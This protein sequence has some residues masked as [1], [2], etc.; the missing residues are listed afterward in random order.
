MDFKSGKPKPAWAKDSTLFKGGLD[1]NELLSS[2][3]RSVPLSR[4]KDNV[5]EGDAARAISNM[6]AYGINK[7]VVVKRGP[8][9]S[10]SIVNKPSGE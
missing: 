4:V 8:K 2:D 7:S 9:D 1:P 5:G 3:D 6:V 10:D